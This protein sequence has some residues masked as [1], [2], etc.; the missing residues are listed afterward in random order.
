MALLDDPIRAEIVP[1]GYANEQSARYLASA[2][3]LGYREPTRGHYQTSLRFFFE[4]CAANGLHPITDVRRGHIEGWAR[5]LEEVRGNK[6]ATVSNRLAAICSFYKWCEIEEYVDKDPARHVRRPKVSNESNTIGLS[7]TQFMALYEA[8]QKRA[9]YH[10]LVCLMA[11]NGLRLSEVLGATIEDMSQARGHQL[12]R[13]H[14]KGSKITLEPLAPPTIHAV[15]LA[16]GD[17]QSGPI[18]TPLHHEGH[19]MAK[20]SAYHAIVRLGEECGIHGLHPHV[21]RHVAI[22]AGLDAGTDL[23]D[24]VVFARHARA[25]T[26]VRYDRN[27]VRLDRH[28]TYRVTGYLLAN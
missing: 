10:A 23:R 18:I 12:L 26:T 5:T 2:F 19:R 6:P 15:T 24:M 9:S 21:L 8:S 3:L 16:I 14:G 25:E 13:I 27:R 4:F 17:R 7:R 1:A 20:T 11:F 22:T 28:A